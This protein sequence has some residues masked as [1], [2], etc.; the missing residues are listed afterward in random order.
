MLDLI[1]L[2]NDIKTEA[3]RLGFTHVGI[4]PAAPVPHYDVFHQWVQAGYHGSMAYLARPDTLDKRADPGLILDSCQ[5]VISLAIAYQPPEAPLHETPPGYGRIA[6]YARSRDYHHIIWEKL[7]QLEDYVQTQ[8]GGIAQ[9]KSYVDTGPIIERAFAVSSGIGI[10][11][12]NTCLIV[13]KVGSYV[14]LAEVLI[15]LELPVDPP[16]TRDLCESC[17]RCIEAC[18]TGCILPDRTIDA[19]RC[20]SYL[21]IE[22]KGVI[23][24]A[25]KGLIGNWFFGCDVCQMVCPHNAR[26]HLQPNLLGE[27]LLPECI[28]LVDLITWDQAAFTHTFK[29][30]ALLRAQRRGLLRNAAIVL[31]NQHNTQALPR[32]KQIL[33]HEPDPIIQDACYW[34]SGQ[35]EGHRG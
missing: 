14:F 8:S 15:N 13:P 10:P 22:N 32:L 7:S 28:D 25:L 30:T 27:P 21:T 26:S 1:N 33:A 35:I 34:A 16:F 4:A 31:G 23:P 17:Q 6:T 29:N 11:G 24:D 3:Q 18:P 12:K 5:R 2:K 19:T 20:I 9:V